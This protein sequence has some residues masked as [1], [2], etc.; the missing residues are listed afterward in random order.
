[1]AI[2]NPYA[3]VYGQKTPI[4]TV[5]EGTAPVIVNDKTLLPVRFLS[6]SIGAKVEWD[7]KTQRITIYGDKRIF[8]TMNS[9]IM[10]V[11]KEKRTLQTPAMEING[12]TYVPLRDIV[13]ALDIGCY[14]EEPGLIICGPSVGYYELLANGGV[15]RLLEEFGLLSY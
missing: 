12:R 10:Q 11:E 5:V 3:Y 2:D 9:N 1:M 13:E 7:E 14:W 15:P 6:E 8:L 4:D